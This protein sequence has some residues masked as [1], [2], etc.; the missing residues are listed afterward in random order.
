M[1][2]IA[3]AEW[4]GRSK[5]ENENEY[6]REEGTPLHDWILETS[7][8]ER[9][10]LRRRIYNLSGYL[11]QLAVDFSQWPHVTTA[12]LRLLTFNALEMRHT[13]CR[14]PYPPEHSL[15]EIQEIQEEDHDRL[16]LLDDLVEEFTIELRDSQDV[17]E[18]FLVR[19][20]VPRIEEVQIELD[21]MRMTAD[22]RLAAELVGIKWETPDADSTPDAESQPGSRILSPAKKLERLMIDIDEIMAEYR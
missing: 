15:E 1:E 7:S 16:S 21:A 22:E 9:Q 14:M 11:Q 12:A 18:Q 8:K 3:T 6:Q 4:D 19:Y 10:A 13:C 5:M 20:W 2:G 17:F